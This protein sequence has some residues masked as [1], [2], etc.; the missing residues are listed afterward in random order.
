VL[1]VTVRYD[2]DGG[3]AATIEGRRLAISL[4]PARA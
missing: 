1:A 2:G 4:R 3:E